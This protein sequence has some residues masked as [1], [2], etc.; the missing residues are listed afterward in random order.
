MLTRGTLESLTP[1]SVLDGSARPDGIANVTVGA[2]G[3]NGDWTAQGAMTTGDVM[4]WFASGA[5]LADVDAQHR[6][7]F[8]VSYGRQRYEGANPAALTVGAESRYAASFGA[9]DRWDISPQLALD[10]GGRYSTYGYIEQDGL[11]SPR[12]AL[13]VTPR[14]GT[15]VHIGGA[16]ETIAPGAEEFLPPTDG[17]GLWLPPERTFASF[18]RYG[19]LH[20][21]RTRHLEIGIEHDLGA[22]F[23]VGVRRFHQDVTDQMATLFGADE[24]GNAPTGHYYIARAGSVTSGGWIVTLRRELGGRVSGSV[25]YSVAEAH[26]V[27]ADVDTALAVAAPG[28]LRPEMERFHDV[29]GTL[30][31]VIPESSTRVLLRCRVNG[32]YA[33]ADAQDPTGLAARFDV[34]IQQA[35]PF[36]PI[37]GSRWEAVLAVRSL[38]FD[39]K[40]MASMFNE[41]LV[42]RP[43][44]QVVGGVVV[45]F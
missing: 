21:E 32:A 34:M 14:R 13:T 6:V 18:S 30:E 25:D 41:L 39:P 17:M 16:Q 12:A 37:D 42:V 1:A 45:H 7:G 4:S 44:K 11:F 24:L 5:Y 43:P 8:D 3:W 22:D 27:Q 2:P 33:R 26:W 23:S 19:G 38:F 9:S 40:D 15:R 35:L 28:V 10:Y 31:T 20:P 36:S 29:S